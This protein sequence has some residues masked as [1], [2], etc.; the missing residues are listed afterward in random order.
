[1]GRESGR[2]SETMLKNWLALMVGNSRLH[3]AWFMES[4]L[5][6]AWDSAHFSTEDIG[7]LIEHHL[8]FAAGIDG[9]VNQRAGLPI[10]SI[11]PAN[12][13]LW[14]ASVIPDQLP[15]WQAYSHTQVITLDR[16]PLQ[17]LY[18]TLGIDRALA[19]L[20][21]ATVYELPCLVIDAGTALTFTAA[22][23]DG[24][25]VGGA[26]LP[27]LQLQLRSLA[28]H[29]AALPYLSSEQVLLPQRWANNTADAIWSGLLYTLLA[30][31]RDFITTWQEQQAAGAIV[32]TG[33]DASLL[34]ELMHQQSPALAAHLRVDSQLIFWGMR[35]LALA[36]YS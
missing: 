22:D 33:G 31:I 29:T 28:E 5:Q 3:W 16:I 17:G 15:L 14:V 25:L 21:A 32:L 20:G 35:H 9:A 4:T 13:P 34:A 27:G 18:S 7:Y 12:L 36:S 6:Q 8:D 11:V 30:G 1:M 24:R 10:G 23:A 2:N 26:I 19:L